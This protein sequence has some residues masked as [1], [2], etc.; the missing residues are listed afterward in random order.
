M[1]EVTYTKK[2]KK[3][4]P[5]RIYPHANLH[6]DAS[7][8]VKSTCACKVATVRVHE[9]MCS[10]VATGVRATTRH[11]RS[12]KFSTSSIDSANKH[13]GHTHEH[14]DTQTSTG[15]GPVH[16]QIDWITHLAV[17]LSMYPFFWPGVPSGMTASAESGQVFPECT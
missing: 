7:Q 17:V 1:H 15:P 16:H 12:T 3:K 11:R 13:S 14:T 6:R 8:R 9:T 10:S 4:L 5:G 2:K